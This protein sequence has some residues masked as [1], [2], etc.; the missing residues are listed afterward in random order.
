LR[1]SKSCSVK[2]TYLI[3]NEDSFS[4]KE[5]KNEIDY[6]HKITRK[7]IEKKEEDFYTIESL[8]DVIDKLMNDKVLNLFYHLHQQF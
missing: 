1:K 6:L 8:K 4:E 3:K 2:E 7:L 5:L